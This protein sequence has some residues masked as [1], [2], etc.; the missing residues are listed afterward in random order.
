[1]IES[2]RRRGFPFLDKNTLLAFALSMLVFVGFLT[3]Q[4]RQYADVALEA[5]SRI[6]Q[7][8]AGGSAADRAGASDGSDSRSTSLEDA[9]ARNGGEDRQLRG[10]ER[11][12]EAG[13]EL[14]G[15]LALAFP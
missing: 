3:Y 12:E 13:R 8:E 7:G 15:E 1:L 9:E 14:P 11:F 10:S 6:A 4:E 5:Q 2:K